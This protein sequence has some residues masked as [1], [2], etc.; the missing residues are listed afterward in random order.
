MFKPANKSTL[1]ENVLHQILDAVRRG[2]WKPGEKIPG[3]LALAE[4]FQV[5][6]NSIRE[7][8]KALSVLKILESKSG[9]GTFVAGNA[10]CQIMNLE[11]T[12]H[13]SDNVSVIELME[14]R[15]LLESQIIRWVIERATDEELESLKR[16]IEEERKFGRDLSESSLEPRAEFH[17]LM[18]EMSG[19]SLAVKALNA[20]KGELDMQRN[21]YLDLPMETWESFMN[22]HEEIL[23]H[24]IN[25][26]AAKAV[27]EMKAHIQKM[28]QVL[29]KPVDRIPSR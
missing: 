8:L 20:I 21:R 3:E 11:L 1:Y 29:K 28:K 13:L 6:R 2:V 17:R 15:I 27:K 19:N 7:A 16:V 26:D 25:R 5:S 14:M 9:Q 18:A 10:L 23:K 24:I 4:Q 22:E 12:N